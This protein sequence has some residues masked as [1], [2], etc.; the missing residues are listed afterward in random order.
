MPAA[1]PT[2]PMPQPAPR[3]RLPWWQRALAPVVAPPVFDFWVRRLHPT[4]SWSRT[5][6]RVVE[7]HV[8]ARDAVTLV[9]K[10]NRHFGGFRPGQHVDVT[11]EVDGVRLTRSYSPAS[12]PRA[13]GRIQ[14]TVKRIAGGRV[15]THLH[16][17]T[18]VGD[19]LE[20]GAAFGDFQLPV[21]PG[22]PMLLLAAGSGI[23]PL[24]SL[25]RAH[26]ARG[27]P[28]PV[29]MLYW[30]RTRDELCFTRALRELAS[31]HPAFDLRF[32]LTRQEPLSE[33]EAQG[34]ID[35][36]MLQRRVPDMAARTV[37]ACGP[38]GFVGKVHALTQGQ[39]R[40]IHL[41]AFTAPPMDL[42]IDGTVRVEL[43]ASGRVLE[44]P[45]NQPLLA[46]LEAQGLHPR[47]GCRMGICNS[48]ACEKLSGTTQHLL[49]R[50]F[51]DE[52]ELALRLCVN[53]PRSDLVLD[54]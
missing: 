30:V 20:L 25:L 48:C 31:R 6:A 4:W 43:R 15:S 38:A 12:I 13:D 23:T 32:V 22:E 45:R 35:A 51:Q 36:A 26:A 14:L 2:I 17:R 28:A 39:A 47:H 5:L 52:P 19:V 10:P 42:D 41:E 49:S 8:E 46:A 54:L 16:E 37:Y 27:F 33:D 11:V 34:H 44:L 1:F 24:M 53:A 21:A 3:S 7:R 9:L 40:A 18:Q 50:D 29:T